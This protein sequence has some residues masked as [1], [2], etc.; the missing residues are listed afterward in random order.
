MVKTPFPY[1]WIV[2]KGVKDEFRTRANTEKI[3]MCTVFVVLLNSI[4]LKEGKI[5]IMS[6]ILG[7]RGTSS[8][9]WASRGPSES[10]LSTFPPKIMGE[11]TSIQP[12]PGPS[13]TFTLLLLGLWS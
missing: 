10:A 3:C 13:S 12:S 6:M 1:S 2:S 11:N 4:R 7:G 8:S 9:P 5:I